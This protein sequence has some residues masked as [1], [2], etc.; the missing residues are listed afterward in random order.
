M[1]EVIEGKHLVGNTNASHNSGQ[2][3][4]AAGFHVLNLRVT[5]N[6]NQ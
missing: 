4:V 2:P 6:G 5:V 3:L 1:R